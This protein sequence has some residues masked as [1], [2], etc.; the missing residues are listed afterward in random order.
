LQRI[1]ALPQVTHAAWTNLVPTRGAFMWNTEIEQTGKSITVYSSHVGPDYFDAA[2]TR[3]LDGRP[4]AATDRADAPRV[5]I[6]NETMAREYFA[7]RDPIGE[8]LKLFDTWV[9]IV[10]VA[11]NTIVEHL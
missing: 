6:V 1:E 8:R 7:G 5:G 9:T 4:F 10:G 11:E 2:G 3:I